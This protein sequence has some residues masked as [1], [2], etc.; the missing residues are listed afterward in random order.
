MRYFLVLDYNGANY[1]GWQR[2]PGQDTVQECI[3]K[4]LSTL[5][6]H[7]TEIT[8]AGR[9]DTGVHARNYAAHFDSD[10]ENLHTDSDFLYKLN[11]ILPFDINIQ[12][13]VKVN[14]DAHARFDAIKRTYRYYVTTRK[15]VFRFPLTHRAKNLDID[16]MN[17]AA[18]ELLKYT[19]FTSFSKLN[20]DVKTNNCTIYK[21]IWAES[22]D[23]E[24]VFTIT[25]NRFLRNMVRA[26]VGTLIEV[27]YGKI[28]IEDFRNIIEAKNRSKAGTS[29]P[30][31]ALFLEEIEY[32]YKV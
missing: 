3:E 28:S 15:D 19:D 5:L 29:A 1:C 9:T 22:T 31:Q 21:A 14:P 18:A 17:L 10:V 11:C 7:E 26:I 2:Q 12:R 24:I 4:A 32:P 23:G 27:G 6:R 20:T 30:A 8:G 25:A 16:K 13:I